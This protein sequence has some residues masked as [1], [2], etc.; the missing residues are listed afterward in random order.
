MTW[1]FFLGIYGYLNSPLILG[2]IKTHHSFFF[3]PVQKDDSGP[4]TLENS[5]SEMCNRRRLRSG[6]ASAGR[7]V[8]QARRSARVKVLRLICARA[9]VHTLTL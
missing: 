6:T 4:G 5:T 3:M 8:V 7:L 2:S 9:P 1:I